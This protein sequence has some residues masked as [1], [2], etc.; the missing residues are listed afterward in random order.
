MDE[1][2]GIPEALFFVYQIDVLI[3]AVDF[4]SG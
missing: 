2:S 4:L 1:A 3:L